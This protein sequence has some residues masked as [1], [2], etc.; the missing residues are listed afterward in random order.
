MNTAALKGIVS[1]SMVIALAAGAFA[2]L[3]TQKAHAAQWEVGVQVGAPV[4]AAGYYAPAP[5]YYDRDYYRDRASEEYLEHERHE[6]W[7]RRQAYLQHE[8]WEQ[9]HRDHEYWEHHRD[10]DRDRD[11]R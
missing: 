10:F 8:Y 6:A 2:V 11:W 9:R 5:V 1:K 4:Y 7:E 3:N